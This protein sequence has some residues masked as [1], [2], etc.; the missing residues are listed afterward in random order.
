MKNPDTIESV[1]FCT[2]AVGQ[3]AELCIEKKAVVDH[4]SVEVVAT[5]IA[6]LSCTR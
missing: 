6:R 4:T 3:Q 2:P 1:L 5:P